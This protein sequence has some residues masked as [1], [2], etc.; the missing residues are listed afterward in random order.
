[1]FSGNSSIAHST[2]IKL[3]VFLIHMTFKTTGVLIIPF[4]AVHRTICDNNFH[5]CYARRA[6]P[7]TFAKLGQK[8][9]APSD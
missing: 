8:K 3:N 6:M 5:K 9:I 7:K 2:M 4:C 1:M